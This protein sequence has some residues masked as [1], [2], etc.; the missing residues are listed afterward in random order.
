MPEPEKFPLWVIINTV[1]GK[2]LRE[3]G[4]RWTSTLRYAC[5]YDVPY[6]FPPRPYE[7][8]IPLEEARVYEIMNA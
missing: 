1:S 3:D 2:F 6:P 4:V 8:I 7:R 5:Q